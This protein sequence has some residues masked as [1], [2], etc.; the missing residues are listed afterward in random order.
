MSY[1]S[2]IIQHR[3]CAPQFGQMYAWS[4]TGSRARSDDATVATFM[5]LCRTVQYICSRKT[6]ARA[7][8]DE[9]WLHVLHH[10][11]YA[12]R[13]CR[14]LACGSSVDSI[15]KLLARWNI[16]PQIAIQRMTSDVNLHI[17]KL[18]DEMKCECKNAQG[19]WC[20]YYMHPQLLL[21]CI[22]LDK[23]WGYWNEHGD[24]VLPHKPMPYY[25]NAH[26]LE[27]AVLTVLGRKRGTIVT[28][29]N[30]RGG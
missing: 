10:R 16:A 30:D 26:S 17:L 20:L 21:D 14:P 22:R 5:H 4:L 6:V 24:L 15:R 2:S 9:C 13:L 27:E 18:A 29:R 11:Y 25:G 8:A 19:M 23:T 3:G 1:E 28:L 7:I 12:F